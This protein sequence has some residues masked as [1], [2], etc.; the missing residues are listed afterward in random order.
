[1]RWAQPPLDPAR[2]RFGRHASL[3]TILLVAVCPA[4]NASA[5]A[6]RAV[7]LGATNVISG[8]RTAAMHV[9]LPV[10][11]SVSLEFL[12]PNEDIVVGGKGRLAGVVLTRSDVDRPE[13]PTLAAIRTSFCTE[14]GCEATAFNVG[15]FGYDGL[16]IGGTGELPAGDYDLYLV[17]DGSSA[18]VVLRLDGPAGTVKLR[19]SLAPRSETYEPER[20]LYVDGA[21]NVY[22]EGRVIEAA[23]DSLWAFAAYRIRGSAWNG[24]RYS[25]CIYQGQ[26][27][28]SPVGFAPG[29]PGGS[30]IDALVTELEAPSGEYDHVHHASTMM[31]TGGTWGYGSNYVT[32]GMV[33][34]VETVA[35]YIDFVEL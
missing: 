4:V 17:A 22:S 28:P 9:R 21:K 15:L 1:M 8:S 19:P 23:G 11:S 31:L 25:R 20:H 26:P 32:S 27:P 2:S 33:D 29:C 3:A 16:Q 10:A 30:E 34:D 7:E 5:P 18:R 12:G 13:R 24:G 35:V 6:S 14:P